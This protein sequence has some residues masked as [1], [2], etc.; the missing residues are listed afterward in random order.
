MHATED[1]LNQLRRTNI[2]TFAHCVHA[3]DFYPS[4]LTFVAELWDFKTLLHIRTVKFA[5]PNISHTCHDR[6]CEEHSKQHRLGRHA[7]GDIDADA[8]YESLWR[9]AQKDAVVVEGGALQKAWTG[10]LSAFENVDAIS[11]R[12]L[13]GCHYDD[14]GKSAIV[15]PTNHNC[16]G[17][18]V[19]IPSCSMGL[20]GDI[21]FKA[22]LQA[23][24]STGRLIKTFTFACEISKTFGTGW[25]DPYWDELSLGGLEGHKVLYMPGAERPLGFFPAYDPFFHDFLEKSHH[26]LQH[27]NLV[28]ESSSSPF[29]WPVP[30]KL[31]FP[32]LREVS[33]E[34]NCFHAEEFKNNIPHFQAL[35]RVII[36]R[37]YPQDGVS[38]WR[39]VFDAIRGHPHILHVEFGSIDTS[40]WSSRVAPIPQWSLTFDLLDE[41]DVQPTTD[42]LEDLRRSLH[43]YLSN[44]GDWDDILEEFFPQFD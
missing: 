1:N 12:S 9:C 38:D 34:C 36:K 35:E 32:K 25:T 4:P 44:K 19:T 26:T 20:C 21:L 42:P 24:A 33:L 16:C 30:E 29:F 41:V 39:L 2:T 11:L 37:C 14:D 3:I 40:R 6:L 17:W 8:R 5:S 43:L 23:L 15:I 7:C 27:L 28:G 18:L 31:D 10:A 13:V 22:V